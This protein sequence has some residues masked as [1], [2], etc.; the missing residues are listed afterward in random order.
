[1][2]NGCNVI[3]L[4][5]LSSLWFMDKQF[6]AT[7]TCKQVQTFPPVRYDGFLIRDEDEAHDEENAD[8]KMED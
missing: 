5:Q 6:G 2:K 1:M 8:V 7:W 3:C 4:I